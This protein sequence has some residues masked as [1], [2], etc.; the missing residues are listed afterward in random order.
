MEFSKKELGLQDQV[1][2]QKLVKKALDQR[3]CEEFVMGLQHKSKLKVYRKLKHG[4]VFEEYLE[5]IKVAPSGLFLK[6]RL[7][8]HGLFE[9]LC[10]D[11]KGV[12][13]GS[14]LIAGLVRNQL[15]MF[16]LNVH[17]MIPRD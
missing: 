9:E 15:S 6:F 2:D 16:F 10:R 14:V 17:H 13:H 12:G 8:T 3:D 5:Y 11:D 1:L 7:G 4:I